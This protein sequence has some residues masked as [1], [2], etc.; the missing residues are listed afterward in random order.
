M[1]GL[2]KVRTGLRLFCVGLNGGAPAWRGGEQE[3]SGMPNNRA[4][5][6]GISVWW[7]SLQL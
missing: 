4:I 2:D 6:Q 3:M 1:E 7:H 5:Q